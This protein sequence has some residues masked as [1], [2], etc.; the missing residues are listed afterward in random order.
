MKL[1]AVRRPIFRQF[2]CLLSFFI[3]LFFYR[4]LRF[5]TDFDDNP[6]DQHGGIRKHF[7][8]PPHPLVFDSVPPCFHFP[9]RKQ[10]TDGCETQRL[11]WHG[12]SIVCYLHMNACSAPLITLPAH[13]TLTSI[14]V[15]PPP[16]IYIQYFS[17]Y[18]KY[19]QVFVVLHVFKLYVVLQERLLDCEIGC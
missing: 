3:Y 14:S 15:P 19:I 7:S 16:R 2:V 12:T 17:F 4:L 18:I 1:Y 6:L 8:P 9:L 10:N 11:T 13:Y 5:L